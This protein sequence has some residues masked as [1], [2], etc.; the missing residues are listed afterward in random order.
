MCSSAVTSDWSVI[1]SSELSVICSSKNVVR[2]L[3]SPLLHILRHFTSTGWLPSA[4]QPR[5][6][7]A[8]SCSARLEGEWPRRAARLSAASRHRKKFRLMSL[9]RTRL[10]AQSAAARVG[11]HHS[12]RLSCA[13][14]GGIS[15]E[16][17]VAW[18]IQ[19]AMGHELCV[20]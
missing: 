17:C 3:Y 18:V 10:V 8:A 2:S 20:Y 4:G 6:R 15:T 11:T 16:P 9:F 19:Y 14:S 5:R 12:R 13:L 1:C 7:H